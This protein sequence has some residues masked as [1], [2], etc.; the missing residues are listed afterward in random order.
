M[1]GLSRLCCLLGG[2]SVP[3]GSEH[4]VGLLQITR[5]RYCGFARFFG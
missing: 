4:A 3:D 2:G 1:I 5:M